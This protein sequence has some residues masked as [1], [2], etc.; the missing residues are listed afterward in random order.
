MLEE[1]RPT[2][3]TTL[4]FENFTVAHTNPNGTFLDSIQKT[5]CQS[6]AALTNQK[7]YGSNHLH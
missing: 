4:T 7:S 5:F 3:N 2:R 1:K 6:A